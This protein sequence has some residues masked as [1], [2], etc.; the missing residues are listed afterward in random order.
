MIPAAPPLPLLTA[1]TTLVTL[2]S[3]R[4][5]GTT[6]TVAAAVPALCAAA[7]A[8]P[9][10]WWLGSRRAA[11]SAAGALVVAR[12][13]AP[14]PA[15]RT[16]PVVAL[17]TGAA[18]A[19]LLLVVRRCTAADATGGPESAARAVALGVGAD[20]ALRLALDLLDP[21]R[22]GGFTGWLI[23]LFVAAPLGVLAWRADRE[24]TGE[25]V[26][27]GGA[28]P[29]LLGPALGLYA[30]LLASPG[31]IAARAGISPAAAGLWIAAG[32][33][34]AVLLLP[35]RLPHR[36]AVAVLPVAVLV[37]AWLPALSPVAA[38]A[39]VAVL[40]ALL[41]RALAARLGTGRGPLADLAL[42]GAGGALGATLL[43]LPDGFAALVVCA[44]LAALGLALAAAFHPAPGDPGT[45]TGAGTGPAADRF[46]PLV[47]AALLLAVPPPLAA[48]RPAP[49][50]LP[51]DTAGGVYRLLTWNVHGAVDRDGEPAPEAIL[52]V[53]EESRAHVVV[54]QEVPR[55]ASGAGGLDL[56]AWLERHLDVETVWARAAD[57]QTG[58]LVLTSLPVRESASGGLPGGRSWARVEVGLVD[59]E[60]ARVVTTHLDGGSDPDTR[61]EQLGPLLRATGDD[62]HTVLAGDLNALPGSPEIDRLRDAGF[63]SA[64]DENGDPDRDTA[65]S[66]ARRV[67]WILGAAGVSF[68]D[69]RLTDTRTSDHLPLTTTVF[70]N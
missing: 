28:E 63:R 25:T 66:P 36:A 39:G 17:V 30:V 50:P 13:V 38:L 56:A 49:D 54:L 8:G 20:V 19:A 11:T 10:P 2:E 7:A 27:D 9:L 44:A 35:V 52:E 61:L 41:R 67:D 15:A 48:A 14:F 65:V 31:L 6:G 45:S 70:L 62:P 69:F 34:L 58:N 4:L 46:V 5:W 68:A 26:A 33:V 22:R 3:L 32:T 55:G 59:G 37:I 23:A 24:A 57:R 51:T 53:I 64:Q 12:L 29:G 42:A 47:V 43:V 18:L 1:V 60:Q 16:V 40:P 21:V